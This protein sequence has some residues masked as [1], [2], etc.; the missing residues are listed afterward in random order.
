MTGKNTITD[1]F[2]DLKAGGDINIRVGDDIH[3]LKEIPHLLTTPPFAPETF[4]GREEEIRAINEIFASG[5]FIVLLSGK[6][7]MG[8]TTLASRYFIEYKSKYKHAAWILAGK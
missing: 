6:G 4:V 7:G 2:Q 5:Q 1:A 8:K 3:A